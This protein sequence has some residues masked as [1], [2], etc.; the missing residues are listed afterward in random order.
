MN[1]FATITQLQ[2]FAMVIFHFGFNWKGV[3]GTLFLIKKRVSRTPSKLSEKSEWILK[4]SGK[5]PL[6]NVCDMVPL[7][8]PPSWQKVKIKTLCING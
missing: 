8:E 4:P 5:L 7:D 2:N 6:C 3:L 1:F